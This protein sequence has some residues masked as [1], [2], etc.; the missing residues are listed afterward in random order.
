MDS[1]FEVFDYCLQRHGLKVHFRNPN[2]YTP[3]L[4]TDKYLLLGND[5]L[6]NRKQIAKFSVKDAE[7][8]EALMNIQSVAAFIK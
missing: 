5:M 6:E 2:S 8:N 4:D 7:V 3:V 1:N